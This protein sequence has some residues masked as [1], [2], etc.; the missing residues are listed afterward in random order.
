MTRRRRPPSSARPRRVPGCAAFSLVLRLAVVLAAAAVPASAAAQSLM[1]VRGLGVLGGTADGRA[2]AVGNLGIGLAGAE[3]SAADPTAGKDLGVP[4]ISLTMQ[5]TWGEFELGPERGDVRAT[6][7][8]LVGIVFPLLRARGAFTAAI[9]G[10]LDQR[11]SGEVPRT[12]D[13][14]QGGVQVSDRFEADG[15]ISVVRVGWVQR[16]GASFATGVSVGAYMGRLDQTFDRELDT[17]ALGGAV[18][19]FVQEGAWRYSGATVTVGASADPHR[20]VHLAG[21]LEWSGDLSESP[22]EGTEGEPR[23]YAIPMRALAGATGRLTPRFAL[24]A[25]I[26]FQDWSG[27]SG[28]ADGA[29]SGG[30]FSYGAGLEATLA[31][32]TTRSVPLRAGY[33]KLAQPFRFDAADSEETVWSVGLGL[34]LAETEGRRRG[35]VDVGVE[36]GRRASAPLVERYWR[37][38]VSL[39]ISQ[40]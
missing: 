35:W 40:F 15:G 32:G 38:T 10:R 5:P 39:G 14:G 4:T 28:F 17:L 25:S 26:A 23:N 24:N 31:Q 12:V 8:P 16:I 30:K 29:T 13:L 19:S 34:T 33:R 11:W 2:A 1:G 36:R 21:A 6:R 27:A 37:A 20:L 9:T 3:V 22:A 7:F 18:Q